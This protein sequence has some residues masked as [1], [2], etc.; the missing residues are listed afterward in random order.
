MC[1]FTVVV[2]LCEGFDVSAPKML[3][4]CQDEHVKS[5]TDNE[6]M[7]T[8]I[9]NVARGFAQLHGLKE[10]HSHEDVEFLFHE[11]HGA[12]CDE[13]FTGEYCYRVNCGDSELRLIANGFSGCLATVK[14]HW[15][16]ND[17]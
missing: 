6:A 15:L 2:C 5:V 12:E 7:R 16:N 1:T 14:W 8:A 10:P 13:Y 3:F 17:L 11:H 9:L 4:I